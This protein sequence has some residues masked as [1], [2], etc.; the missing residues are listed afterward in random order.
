MDFDTVSQQDINDTREMMS[1]SIVPVQSRIGGFTPL[2][3]SLAELYGIIRA[4]VYGKVWRYCQ[5]KDGV[6]RA[7]LETLADGMGVDRSTISRHLAALCEDGYIKDLTPD[8]RNRP[9]VYSDTGK[10]RII[11]NITVAQ[12]NTEPETVAQS[13]VTVAQSRLSKDIKRDSKRE[14]PLREKAPRTRTPEE[15]ELAN[16]QTLFSEI[17]GLPQPDPQASTKQRK[18]DGELWYQP[19]RRIQTACNGKSET[20]IRDAVSRLRKNGL[21]ISSPKSI[22]K[23]TQAIYGEMN[24]A[25]RAEIP[26]SLTTQQQADIFFRDNPRMKKDAASLEWWTSRGAVVS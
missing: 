21:T 8:L 17:T 10:S 7:S 23:T 3:D 24:S 19:I 12:C 14:K 2:I 5:M 13:N 26:K 16:L 6:C 15:L 25:G 9:H 18:A 11:V 4:A 20:V 1:A 22:E